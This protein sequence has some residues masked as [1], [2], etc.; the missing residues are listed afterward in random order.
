M[1]N[2]DMTYTFI[3][4]EYSEMQTTHFKGKLEEILSEHS[5]YPIQQQ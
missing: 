5:Q 4:A 3:A 1:I 2:L